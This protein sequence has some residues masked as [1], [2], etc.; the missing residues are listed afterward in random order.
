MVSLVNQL[1]VLILVLFT[2]S[3][4]PTQAPS[5]LVFKEKY[6]FPRDV[7][8]DV[9]SIDEALSRTHDPFGKAK[10]I[11]NASC[12]RC[13]GE[14]THYS[15]QSFIYSGLITPGNPDD[16]I[17][18]RRSKYSGSGRA[19]MPPSSSE[20]D[21]IFK[22]E[23][24]EYLR[25]WVLAAKDLSETETPILL[26]HKDQVSDGATPLTVTNI[27]GTVTD[28]IPYVEVVIKNNSDK[29]ITLSNAKMTSDQFLYTG[30]ASLKSQLTLAKNQEVKVSFVI[31]QSSLGSKSAN[32]ELKTSASAVPLIVIS[33]SGK[34][35][36]PP[37]SEIDS[38]LLGVTSPFQRA[39]I[40]MEGTCFRCHGTWQSFSEQDF[41]D[42]GLI[43][44]E[45][46]ASSVIILK[47][48]HSGGGDMP[49][50]N[51]VESLIFRPDYHNEISTW[52][53]LTK[54]LSSN[55]TPVIF[56]YR[57]KKSEGT[58]ELK[59]TDVVGT[60]DSVLDSIVVT[61]QNNSKREINFSSP[62]MSSSQ[63]SFLGFGKT[64]LLS[65]ESTDLSFAIN[66]SSVGTKSAKFEANTG[67]AELPKITISFKGEI[68]EVL[69][70][71]GMT[72]NPS[73]KVS[74]FPIRRLT[75]DQYLESLRIL[76]GSQAG[77]IMAEVESSL[78]VLPMDDNSLHYPTMD[79]KVTKTHTDAYYII[80]RDIA[81]AATSTNGRLSNIAGSCAT[82][83][84]VTQ[85][86]V[87]NFIKDFGKKVFRRPL[88]N[89]EVTQYQGLYNDE[90]DAKLGFTSIIQ[91]F[92]TSPN[93]TNEIILGG[94]AASGSEAN[95]Y[96]L[97]A[98]ELTAKAYF[99][100]VGHTPD[101][102]GLAQADSGS[103]LTPAGYDSLIDYLFGLKDVNNVPKVNKIYLTFIKKWL[104]IDR[105]AS[106]DENSK[107]LK[108][109]AGADLMPPAN[110]SHLKDA[111]ISLMKYIEHHFFE[112][113][114]N[115]ST[116]M[117]SNKVYAVSD[118]LKKIFKVS[119]KSNNVQTTPMA[120]ARGLLLHPLF[121]YGGRPVAE[122]DPFPRGN[123][124]AQNI[125]CKEIRFP[126]SL[127]EGS[128]ELPEFDPNLTTRDRFEAKTSSD[129]CMACHKII[130]PMGFALEGFDVMGR[131]S[132]AQ[133]IYSPNNFELLNTLTINDAVTA[134]LIDG[135]YVDIQGGFDLVRK[136]DESKVSHACFAKNL[137]T[138]TS[139]QKVKEDRYCTVKSVYDHLLQ[140][141][142]LKDV[143]KVL[144]KDESFKKVKR[145]P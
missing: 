51:S 63:F 22:H 128:L 92:L 117:T 98:Y 25:A 94:T 66:Q 52:I 32:F 71:L 73:L 54:D 60:T 57:G 45:D 56:S 132:T 64:K 68:K 78:A 11:L 67:L 107:A 123:K 130:N 111:E 109:L 138:F 116:F 129:S 77:P 46:P 20:E 27:Q 3:C 14:W 114:S 85:N 124:I 59:I 133:K 61:V 39:K 81:K 48:R 65:G 26:V 58:N 89:E 96:N 137:V 35:I 8:L 93:F 38:K 74:P 10:I 36:D 104:E 13:H 21:K 118:T 91:S 84:S 12:Y 101:S 5:E 47:S 7:S 82:Q 79:V 102:Y 86:C 110:G 34:I 142:P 115:Y 103:V 141:K 49:P 139:G 28:S 134:E 144:V 95:V 1:L 145:T 69:S 121:L 135:V 87:T 83:S 41:I 100:I 50:S 125:L 62:K 76:L 106:F 24:H 143:L 6:D 44:A 70:A 29:S 108:D 23:Y 88:K 53:A 122:N 42:N 19:A 55:G 90:G 18:I 99:T 40:I 72:C 9:K 126:T 113:N 17:L 33:L 140:N 136:I 15:E 119:A 30:P 2:T 131:Y 16:S 75:R 97:T 37:L 120:E 43:T 31:D 127:D 80:G 112:N 4:V 105:L